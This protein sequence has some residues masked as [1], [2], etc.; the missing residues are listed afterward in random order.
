MSKIVKVKEAINIAED[1]HRESKTIVVVGGCFD[2]LHPGH[3]LFLEKAKKSG[4]ILFVM[5]ES[6]KTI[7][8]LK[9]KNRPIHTQKNR[10][11]ILSSIGAVDYVIL[12]PPLKSD[13]DYDDLLSKIK[14]TIIAT[15]KGDP[16]KHH[17]ER[18]AKRM[19]INVCE[20]MERMNTS[21]SQLTKL[22]SL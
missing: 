5:L 17:K 21:T 18:Q 4:D 20:V 15:T 7:Q 19:G 10:S 11:I 3:I 12:L 14:P 1:F 8:K 9:G 6:D 2:I 22:L 16:N 13:Q